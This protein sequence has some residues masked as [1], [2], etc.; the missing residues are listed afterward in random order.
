MAICIRSF[1]LAGAIVWAVGALLLGLLSM[2]FGWGLA[3][4]NTISSI[5]IGYAPTIAGSLIGALWAFADAYIACAIFAWIYNRFTSCC[6][7]K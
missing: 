1:A 7:E 2:R 5:Y 6:K 3:M 4:V